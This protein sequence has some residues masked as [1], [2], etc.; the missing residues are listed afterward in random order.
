MVAAFHPIDDNLVYFF[1]GYNSDFNEGAD[2]AFSLNLNTE[3]Y[4]TLDFMPKKLWGHSCVGFVKR[5]GSPVSH[6]VF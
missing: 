5:N 2:T 4:E 1:G 6:I 3:E